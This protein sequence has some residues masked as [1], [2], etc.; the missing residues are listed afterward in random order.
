MRERFRE[1][2]P[3]VDVVISCAGA[4][5]LTTL[6]VT[7]GIDIALTMSNSVSNL[8]E[9]S[10]REVKRLRK[11]LLFSADH[12]LAGRAH[13]PS[14]PLTP[15]D[16]KDELFFAPWETMDRMITETITEYMRPYG[17]T[18]KIRFVQNHESMITCVRNDMGVAVVD[19]WVWAKNAPDVA[20]IPLDMT[21]G[22]SV[23]RLANKKS[24]TIDRMEEI[25]TGIIPEASD[26]SHNY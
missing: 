12:R 14:Q 15:R 1:V 22:I 6:L 8:R 17:F 26:P 9:L 21:D 10:A 7:D 5:D 24:E 18:P 11:I 25:L 3:D 16:F 13:D 20:W 2:Y 19:E 4:K 23:A